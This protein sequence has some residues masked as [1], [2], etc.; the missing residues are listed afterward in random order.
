[1]V[2]FMNNKY[3]SVNFTTELG[4]ST[5]NFLN[6]TITIR[7]CRHAYLH[8]YHCARFFT[9]PPF[10]KNIPYHSYIHRLVSITLINELST[11]KYLAQWK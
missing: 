9:L 10:H 4:G 3:Q 1:M 7:E 2:M 6:S 8:E 11:I 5:I